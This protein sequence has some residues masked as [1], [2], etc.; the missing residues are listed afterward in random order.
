MPL[1]EQQKQ[2]LDA[3][4]E[5]KPSPEKNQRKANHDY[6]SRCIYM[7][8]MCVDGRRPLFGEL[9]PPDELHRIPHVVLSTLG[10]QVLKLWNAIPLHYPDVKVLKIQVMPDHIHGILFFT[11]NVPYHLGQVVNG[12]KK[13]CNDAFNTHRREPSF[14]KLWENGYND[15][16]LTGKG[17][18]ERMT[19]YLADNPRRLWIKKYNSDLF[20]RR[21]VTI[22]G[23]DAKM[24][25]NIHL[26][27]YNKKAYVQCTNKMSDD[28]VEKVKKHFIEM[29]EKGY[30]PVTAGI[31]KGEKAVMNWALDNG[32]ELILVTNNGMSRLW[33]PSGRQFDACANGKLLIVATGEY[34]NYP[35]GIKRNICL[36]LNDIALAIV[37]G[38]TAISQGGALRP[39]DGLCL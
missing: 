2:W 38:K 8:T 24:M 33:K 31:S 21:S 6:R 12:F 17:H 1:S 11:K 7:I 9:C 30:V 34:Q 28:E 3:H 27:K 5:L 26:L 23:T 14:N 36:A 4:P 32:H 37:E 19:R 25:G 15:T 29:C 35:H 22:D 10:K 13:G 39:N 18:L 20:V 16:I